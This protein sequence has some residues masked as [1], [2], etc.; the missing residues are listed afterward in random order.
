MKFELFE[1]KRIADLNEKK[2]KG[3]KVSFSEEYEDSNN[4]AVP[5]LLQKRKMESEDLASRRKERLK[6][7]ND[8]AMEGK[9]YIKRII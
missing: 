3:N 5:D 6:K 8:A 1:K 9:L 7:L 4:Q 2:K